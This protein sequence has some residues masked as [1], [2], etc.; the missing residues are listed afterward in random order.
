MKTWALLALTVF[1]FALSGDI[2]ASRN[3]KCCHGCER[4][5][6]KRSNCGDICNLGPACRGCWTDCSN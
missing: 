2:R 1:L 3:V 5:H 6:C 4:Y